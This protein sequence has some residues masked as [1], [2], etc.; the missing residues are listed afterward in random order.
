[1]P[2]GSYDPDA[3]DQARV[4]EQPGD[5]W[6]VH[7]DELVNPRLGAE[8]QGAKKLSDELDADLHAA[9]TLRVVGGRML[10]RDGS[11]VAALHPC[12]FE[13]LFNEGLQGLLI[14]GF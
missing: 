7:G 11:Q 2:I 8:L 10:L 14:V 13:G 1:M 4:L 12:P 9:V 5:H 6:M 3:Q